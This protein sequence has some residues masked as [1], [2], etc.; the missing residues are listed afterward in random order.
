MCTE[1]CRT[2]QNRTCTEVNP[3]SSC[4]Q[5]ELERLGDPCDEPPCVGKLLLFL[6]AIDNSLSNPIL[7]IPLIIQLSVKSLFGAPGTIALRVVET[8]QKPGTGT[9]QWL[10]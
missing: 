2:L 9:S 1:S 8:E 4:K 3:R 10:R 5:E 6:P 7:F